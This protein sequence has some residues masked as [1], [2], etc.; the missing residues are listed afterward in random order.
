MEH[1]QRAASLDARRLSAVVFRS[2]FYDGSLSAAQAAPLQIFLSRSAADAV[3][4]F[5]L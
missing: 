2:D 5:S 4:A 1:E 3:P